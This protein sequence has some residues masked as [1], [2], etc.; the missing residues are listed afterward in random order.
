MLQTGNH[1]ADVAYYIGEDAPKMTGI[2]KPELPGGYDYDYINAEVIEKYLTVKNGRFVL[3]D[4]MSYRLLVLPES[5]TM[6]PGVL[7]KLGKLAAAGGAILGPPPSRSPSLENFPACDDDVKTLAADIWKDNKVMTGITLDQAFER[8]GVTPDVQVPA[9]LLWKHRS[10]GKTD[11][12][13][14]ANTRSAARTE[15]ISFRTHDRIPELWWPETGKIQPITDYQLREGRLHVPITFATQGSVFV[16][17]RQPLKAPQSSTP[18]PTHSLHILKAT[19]GTKDGSTNIDVTD[20]LAAAVHHGVLDLPITNE[21][22]GGDPAPMQ[23]KQ[24]NV[25]FEHRGKSHTIT[26]AENSQLTLPLFPELKGP[27][28]VTYPDRTLSFDQLISWTD[29]PLPEVKYF[30]GTAI[31]QKKFLLSDIHT[32]IHLDL[33]TVHAIASVKVNGRTITTL[34]K[35]PYTTEITTAVKQGTN[36]LEIQVTNAWHNRLVGDQ[37]LGTRPSSFTT[38]S[39]ITAQTPL[40]PSGLLG[41]VRLIRKD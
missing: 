27:W 32:P 37:Q 10:D 17:F 3:P 33:G 36:T 7:N 12:Y 20:R 21:T 19:Y 41:P 11:L 13:F 18:P 15:T 30:S 40:Q 14:L 35:P 38:T 1:V 6:R 29:H 16:V 26:Q 22:L 24:L 25:T 5:A 39:P 28:K 2:R 23:L 31:Y 4:G 9:D 8:L 34:W